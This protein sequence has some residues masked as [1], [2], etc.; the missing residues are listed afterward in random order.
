M[1]QFKETQFCVKNFKIKIKMYKKCLTFQSGDSNPRFSVIFPPMV[2]IFMEGECDEIKSKQAS[3]RDRTFFKKSQ[4]TYRNDMGPKSMSTIS[5]LHNSTEL[6]ITN[7]SLLTS[8]AN[9]SWSDP[10]LDNVSSSK[11]Q[12]F[13][14]L[15]SD[16]IARQNGMSRKSFANFFYL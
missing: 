9:R 1:V 3:K 16:N 13:S 14:H 7:S 5:T 10:N 15:P 6:R 2:W 4:K 12:S 8:C 11:Y